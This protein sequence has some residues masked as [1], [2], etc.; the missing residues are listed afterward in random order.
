VLRDEIVRLLATERSTPCRRIVDVTVGLGGHSAALLAALPEGAELL[1]LDRDASALELASRRLER[2]GARAH[3]VQDRFSSL[4]ERLDALGWD[5]VDAV[6][7][8]LGVS[9]LQLDQAARG[10]SFQRPATLDM[11]MDQSAGETAAE[12]L[13][14]LDEAELTELLRELGEEPDARRIARALCSRPAAERPRTTQD[15]RAMVA[16]ASRGRSP[17]RDPATLTFQ[18]LRIAVNDE[19]AELEAL[20]EALPGRLAPG[21]RV[22]F[23]SYHSLE[24]RRVKQAMQRWTASCTCPPELRV[25]ACGGRARAVRVTRGAERPAAAEVDRN[26]RA[27]SARLRVVEW[28]GE[29]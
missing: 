25:C 8:D 5:R 12:L 13:E 14:R 15:L 27:R 24:D 6:L 4:P 22:G 7:G 26:P 18:A 2:F 17:R 23:L 1:G 11:R 9:S 3:L 20:L 29:R 21:A 19:L 10:F 28:I 16:S